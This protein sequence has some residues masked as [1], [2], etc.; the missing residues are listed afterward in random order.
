MQRKHDDDRYDRHDDDRY[1]TILSSVRRSR[2]GGP[3]VGAALACLGCLAFAFF[4]AACDSGGGG[5]TTTDDT[6]ADMADTT[7][8]T[9]NMVAAR[10]PT[11][12][13]GSGFSSD[14]SGTPTFTERT[15]PEL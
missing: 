10:V 8:N 14:P 5:S 9:R 3:N 12:A 4:L 6:S 7:S 15:I 11:A 13:C 1:D 2:H